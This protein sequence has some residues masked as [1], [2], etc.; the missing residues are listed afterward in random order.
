MGVDGG[1]GRRHNARSVRHDFVRRMAA[2]EWPLHGQL[3]TIRELAAAYGV[4]TATIDRVM[5][6]LRERGLVYSR[7]GQGTYLA[8]VPRPGDDGVGGRGARRPGDGR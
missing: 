7:Q 3:P 2:G 6:L 4:H 1:A 8:R 5:A